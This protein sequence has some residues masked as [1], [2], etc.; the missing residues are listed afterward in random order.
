LVGRHHEKQVQAEVLGWSRGRMPSL[1]RRWSIHA[2]TEER[3]ASLWYQ[4][5][6]RFFQRHGVV[7]DMRTAATRTGGKATCLFGAK[8]DCIHAGEKRTPCTKHAEFKPPWNRNNARSHAPRG[9]PGKNNLGRIS[10]QQKYKTTVM[11]ACPGSRTVSIFPASANELFI[12]GDRNDWKKAARGSCFGPPQCG[13]RA[14]LGLRATA[15]GKGRGAPAEAD[16][17]ARRTGRGRLAGPAPVAQGAEG[18]RPVRRAEGK[19]PRRGARDGR[20]LRDAL[21]ECAT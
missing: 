17:I 10:N 3:C 20:H 6:Q 21:A 13:L 11:R 14:Q 16:G 12:R 2:K 7:S 1:R 18:T 15:Q 9:R 4:K 19:A 5:R 8:R